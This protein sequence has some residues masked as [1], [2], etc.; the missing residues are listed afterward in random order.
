MNR[1][2]I[3]AA[4]VLL[5]IGGL[6][7]VA[8]IINQIRQSQLGRGQVA[9]ASFAPLP[10]YEPIPSY[11]PIVS[12]NPQPSVNPLVSVTPRPSATM[13][14]SPVLPQGGKLPATGL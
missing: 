13:S 11:A 5:V 4:T 9:S 10:S 7:L 8:R 6:F 1:V 14:A 3:G 2:I 12:G